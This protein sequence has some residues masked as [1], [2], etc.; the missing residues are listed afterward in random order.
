[1]IYKIVKNNEIKYVSVKH[2]SYHDLNNLVDINDIVPE[3]IK[4]DQRSHIS[5]PTNYCGYETLYGVKLLYIILNKIWCIKDNGLEFNDVVKYIT[6][7][8][9]NKKSLDILKNIKKYGKTFKFFL[10]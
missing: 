8:P 2:S 10:A 5:I 4:V 9:N 1:M 3:S 7:I 6:P